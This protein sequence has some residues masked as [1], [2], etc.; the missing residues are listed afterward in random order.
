LATFLIGLTVEFLQY[1]EKP[2][3][4]QTYDPCDILMYALGILLG[5]SFDMVILERFEKNES[6]Y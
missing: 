2:I 1:F 6:K 4:G 3:F 5:L